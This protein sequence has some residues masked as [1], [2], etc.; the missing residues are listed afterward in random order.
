MDAKVHKKHS[1]KP[2]KLPYG[3]SLPQLSPLF[4]QPPYDYRDAWSMVISFRSDPR[5]IAPYLP[6]PLVGDPQGTMFVTTSR[7][8]ASGFGHYNEVLVGAFAKYRGRPVN[9][10]LY[11]L[12]DND[13]AIAAGREIWG[14]PKKFGRVALTERD[15]VVSGE[16]ERGGLP[17]IRAAMEIGPQGSASEIGGSAEYTCLKLV[18]SIREG[19]APEVMQLTSTTLSNVTIKKVYKG[20]ATLQFLPSPVDRFSEIPV[21][22]VLGGVYYNADFT[23]G[24]GEVLHDYLS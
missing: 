22:E 20:R 7:F 11:L 3:Y 23:L 6:K 4:M 19:A 12:L 8:F 10:C 16:V 18:P 1:T 15:G 2:A 5:A 13:I 24:H 9:H 21:R 14:F 17:L